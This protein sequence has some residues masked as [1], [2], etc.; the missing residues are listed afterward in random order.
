MNVRPVVQDPEPAAPNHKISTI[1]PKSG[2]LHPVPYT[3]YP[4]PC[5]LGSQPS[6]P[7]P[8]PYTLHTVPCTLHPQPST[9]NTKPGGSTPLSASRP[10]RVRS[11]LTLLQNDLKRLF[12][13]RRPEHR[14]DWVT[15]P[16]TFGCF[17][18]VRYSSISSSPGKPVVVFLA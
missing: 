6:A 3:I 5:T 2:T 10:T 4:A 8:T 18:W 15:A 16:S 7:H 17:L 14:Q 12:V 9:L 13:K 11:Y 1:H